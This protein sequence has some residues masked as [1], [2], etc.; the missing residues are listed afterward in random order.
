MY[1]PAAEAACAAPALS[2][3][4]RRPPQSSP[5]PT[6]TPVLKYDR[7]PLNDWR[8]ERLLLRNPRNKRHKDTR[9]P[10]MRSHKCVFAE[11]VEPRTQ[12]VR[13]QGVAFSALG[14][15]GPPI[16]APRPEGFGVFNFNLRPGQPF[17]DAETKLFQ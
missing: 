16:L 14:H 8:A 9:D 7:P 17:P 12:A 4:Q 10:A 15:K 11:A 13:E 5:D 2:S 1:R 3:V 6:T